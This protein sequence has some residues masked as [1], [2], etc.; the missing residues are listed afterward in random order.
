MFSSLVH[1]GQYHFT[2]DSKILLRTSLERSRQSKWYHALQKPSQA[3]PFSVTFSKQDPQ[4]ARSVEF[5]FFGGMSYYVRKLLCSLAASTRG[6]KS[7]ASPF[8]VFAPKC[9][10]T[11]IYM[12]EISLHIGSKLVYG[13]E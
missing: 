11:Y 5:F 3:T 2:L 13:Q 6:P 12:Y 4:G 10:H 8:Q 7:Y 9:C 1:S